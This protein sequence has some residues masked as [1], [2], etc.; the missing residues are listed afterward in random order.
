M[1]SKHRMI[2]I[3][4]ILGVSLLF[5]GCFASQSRRFKSSAVDFLYPNSEVIEK[6]SIPHLSLPLRVGIAFVPE[7]YQRFAVNRISSK[8]KLDLLKKISDRFKALPF[9]KE[10]ELIPTEYLRNGGG[11]TNLDQIKTMY[12]I[13]VIALVSYDQVQ[14]TDDSMLSFSYFTI[15]GAF[16]VQGD[17]NDTNT[18]IDVVVYD[19]ASRK[20][21]FR[22]PGTS[23][24]NHRSSPVNLSEEL[25]KDS[26]EGFYN[27]ADDLIINLNDALERFKEKVKERPEEYTISHKAGYTGGGSLGLLYSIVLVMLGG[28]GLWRRKEK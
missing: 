14:H 8:D 17:K 2:S 27:A 3:I 22:A 18:M 26:M 28:L 24:V 7:P 21:L 10:I 11:F 15:I 23:L 13:D 19:I 12:N 16:V 1:K 25:R 6:V 20:L 4:F 9:V 5:N